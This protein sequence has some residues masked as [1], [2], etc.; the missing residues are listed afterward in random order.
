MKK[1]AISTLAILSSIYATSALADNGVYVTGSIGSSIVRNYDS[2]VTDYDSYSN[3][4]DVSNFKN[5]TSGV[6]GGGIAVGYDFNDQFQV[7]VRIELNSTFRAKADGSTYSFNDQ[8][9]DISAKNKIR[10][11]TYMLN[12]YYDFY[13]QS[14][15][16]PYVTAGIGM[17]NLKS[18]LSVHDYNYGESGSESKSSNNFAWGL[19]LGVNY[20]LASNILVDASY[21]YIDG[22]KLKHTDH[23]MDGYDKYE[24]KA[25][26]HD[27]MLGL[28]YKF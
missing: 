11:N 28:T 25:S 2:K 14:D 12:G 24:T 27:L 3:S 21:K 8:Y 18:T 26:T 17:S 19:G 5:K 7:P 15:F 6:F 22:G 4:S 20:K 1:L 10:M 16:T 23:Y 13:N 9:D